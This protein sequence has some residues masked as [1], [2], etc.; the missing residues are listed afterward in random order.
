ML[1][2]PHLIIQSHNQGVGVIG[3]EGGTAADPHLLWYNGASSQKYWDL[4][5]N[6]KTSHT[7]TPPASPCRGKVS[8]GEGLALVKGALTEYLLPPLYGV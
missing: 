2:K 7:H 8:L 4:C 1:L 5:K 6:K 3:H